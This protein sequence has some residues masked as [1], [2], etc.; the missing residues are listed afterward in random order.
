M[1]PFDCIIFIFIQTKGRRAAMNNLHEQQ[2]GRTRG[3]AIQH[4]AYSN[5]IRLSSL[6]VHKK[7]DC[8]KR[9]AFLSIQQKRR[10]KRIEWFFYRFHT[11]TLMTID[12]FSHLGDTKSSVL[13]ILPLACISP[14]DQPLV[15]LSSRPGTKTIPGYEGFYIVLKFKLSHPNDSETTDI[16]DLYVYTS[17]KDVAGGLRRRGHRVVSCPWEAGS[18]DVNEYTLEAGGGVLTNRTWHGRLN[19]RRYLHMR[20]RVSPLD[21]H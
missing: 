15:I 2:R 10:N 14:A 19:H 5:M 20:L 11:V 6:N 4:R 12:R 8:K 21:L 18:F 17:Y 13:P 9:N 16:Y 1:T 7:R 3:K